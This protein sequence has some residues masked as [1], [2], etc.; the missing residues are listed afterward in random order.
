MNKVGTVKRLKEETVGGE[1]N[2]DLPFPSTERELFSK[3][4]PSVR[5]TLL[6]TAV[7]S[8]NSLG[9]RGF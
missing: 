7:I 6:L 5:G 9:S 4:K 1:T 2:D 8:E 3:E